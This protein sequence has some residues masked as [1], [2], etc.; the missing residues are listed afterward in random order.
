M[1]KQYFE[2]KYLKYKNKYFKQKKLHGGYK[3]RQLILG[4]GPIGLY[5][6]I[7]LIELNQQVTII[8]T[9]YSPKRKQILLINQQNYNKLTKYID[10]KYFCKVGLPPSSNNGRICQLTV[11]SDN[12][13]YSIP[14]YLLQEELIKKL[15]EYDNEVY[16]HIIKPAFDRKDTDSINTYTD[17]LVDEFYPYSG[18]L[19]IS[20][21]IDGIP[22]ELDTTKLYFDYFQNI[23]LCTGGNDIISNYIYKTYFK[24]IFICPIIKEKKY[25]GFHEC[26]GDNRETRTIY[27]YG[28]IS[29]LNFNTGTTIDDL[30]RIGIVIDNTEKCTL[31]N[32]YK[33]KDTDSN[34]LQHRYRLFICSNVFNG[35]DKDIAPYIYLGT[36]FSNE[37]YLNNKLDKKYI[38]KCVHLALLYY[39][40]YDIIDYR[41][42]KIELDKEQPYI[43][44]IH[45]SLVKE[46]LFI[47][48]IS[49]TPIV[50]MGDGL[51]NINFFSGT[52]VNFGLNEVTSVVSELD[53][54]EFNDIN[55]INNRLL[56]KS[57]LAIPQSI[58]TV[59]DIFKKSI[60]SLKFNLV[61]PDQSDILMKRLI[62]TISNYNDLLKD[63]LK[64]LFT[65]SEYY[66][67]IL[68]LFSTF[69]DGN[70]NIYDNI[71]K[72]L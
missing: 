23:F 71:L 15:N 50:L 43:F 45:I 68:E 56:E 28:M 22:D 3:H 33:I 38:L 70:M 57:S 24:Q 9:R 4:M 49:H 19:V 41:K 63:R 53:K 12:G 30:K 16:V 59:E 51:L 52:G 21:K 20:R 40:I 39:G 7:E 8:E 65:Y 2:Y 11:P 34:I 14:T 58:S 67:P 55:D 27:A 10:T 64:S 66:L 1:D 72:K 37:E 46:P 13:Q 29:F 60:N 42:F 5:L 18:H 35:I 32:F 69:N 17:F 26:D 62:L 44:P 31:N 61:L 25:D 48:Q 47:T 54:G 6:A 36:Q